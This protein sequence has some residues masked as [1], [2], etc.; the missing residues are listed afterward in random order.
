[1]VVKSF[2]GLG[3]RLGEVGVEL[4]GKA[5]VVVV[6]GLVGVGVFSFPSFFSCP[7]RSGRPNIF[8]PKSKSHPTPNPFHPK[9]PIS[10]QKE[11]IP[12]SQLKPSADF[13]A[14]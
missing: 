12:P 4:M 11:V 1:M 9:P 8:P 14:L 10:S 3:T 13:P 5:V 2:R 7:F 6:V